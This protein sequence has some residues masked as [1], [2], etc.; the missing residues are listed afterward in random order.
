MS[1]ALELPEEE[2]RTKRSGGAQK[3]RISSTSPPKQRAPAQPIPWEYNEQ[4][5]YIHV[6]DQN[7][8]FMWE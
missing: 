2:D 1:R 4:E 5:D 6:K 3:D 7:R 8:E